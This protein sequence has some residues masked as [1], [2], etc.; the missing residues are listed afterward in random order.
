ML[1]LGRLARVIARGSVVA[2]LAAGLVAAPSLGG[3]DVAHA[4]GKGP[5]YTWARIDV[6]ASEK[7]EALQKQ[8]KK[9]LD[10]AA[11]KAD[12]GKGG[13]VALSVK[14]VEMVSVSEGDVHRVRCTM[15]GRIVGGPSVKS[16]ISF[17]GS[18]ADKAKLEKQVLEMVAN[19]VVARLAEIARNRAANTP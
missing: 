9:I 16:R 11:K 13:T 4:R 1:W 3:V 18:P 6:P 17:G 12:F 2:V 19:A 10:K 8:L 7:S 5:K 14:V 15:I